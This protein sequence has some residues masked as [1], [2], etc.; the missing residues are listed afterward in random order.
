[1]R[2][3]R[4]RVIG[5]LS[6]SWLPLLVLGA[7]APLARNQVDV[8]RPDTGGGVTAKVAALP[9]GSTKLG[10]VTGD[11]LR[12]QGFV[13]GMVYRVPNGGSVWIVAQQGVDNLAIRRAYNLLAFFL[14]P[15]D[16]LELGSPA[17]KNAVA[18]AMADN[19]AMLMMPTGRHR[20]GR[21]P[22][23]PAQPLFESENPIDGSRWYLEND[24]EHRDAA[25][26]EI[27]HLVHDTGI[28]TYEP[29]ALPAFQAELDREA[30]KAIRDGRW[31][32]PIERDI[33]DWLEELEEEDSLAQEYIA[34]VI[35]S[36]YGLWAAFKERAGG[37]WGIYCAKNRAEIRA[38]DAPGLGLLQRFLPEYMVG[39]EALIA[40]SFQGMFSLQ[41]DPKHAY[42]L[43]SQYLVEATLHGAH[44]S[45]LIGNDQDNV[46][47][48]NHGDN[49]LVGGLGTDTVR[50][51]GQQSEYEILMHGD[52]CTVRDR[53]AA[54][55]GTDTLQSVEVL[56]FTD[57][58]VRVHP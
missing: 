48:G 9:R 6:A 24:W 43:K 50:F 41:L 51:S 37:M 38:L 15:V 14:R 17:T 22:E 57:G 56:R 35:D 29:G 34:A 55:D 12:D 21:E 46:L 10:R 53:I 3:L 33:A 1:M 26:E 13:K 52:T 20:E 40:P 45:G 42:T 5:G 44:A 28:G 2:D 25:F 49:R 32:I 23:V 31:G 8:S 16:G 58:D 47:M 36:Y 27:F 11:Y 18:N 4:Q 30:R 39:Y 54:R 19:G 7:C